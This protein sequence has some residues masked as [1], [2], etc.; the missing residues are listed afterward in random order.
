MADETT[1]PTPDAQATQAAAD[2]QNNLAQ[3]A[4]NSADG[5]NSATTAG[6][7]TASA[8]KLTS[9]TAQLAAAALFG[10]SQATVAFTTG[11][12]PGKI[13]TFNKQLEQIGAI[14]NRK[15]TGIETFKNMAGSM[16]ESLTRMGKSVDS[17]IIQSLGSSSVSVVAG[18]TRAL[19]DYVKTV[20]KAGD[21]L[22]VVREGL[23]AQA[24]ASGNLDQVLHRAGR[25]MQNFNDIASRQQKMWDDVSQASGIAV[26]DVAKYSAELNKVPGVLSTMMKEVHGGNKTNKLFIDTLNLFRISG[27]NYADIT[28][29]MSTATQQMGLSQRAAL[30]YTARMSVAAKEI[31]VPFEELHGAI[32]SSAKAFKMFTTEGAAGEAMAKNLEATMSGYIQTLRSSGI[33]MS[34]AIEMAG[35]FTGAMHE[36]T[37]GQKAF[38]S[39]MTGGPGG[40]MGAFQIEKLMDEGKIDQ[41]FGKVQDTLRKQFGRIVTTSQAAQSQ[42]AA[43]QMTRQIQILRQGP[44]GKFASSDAE[45]RRLLDSMSKPGSAANLQDTIKDMKKDAPMERFLQMGNKIAQ[46]SQGIL[47]NILVATSRGEHVGVSAAAKVTETGLGARTFSRPGDGVGVPDA[48]ERRRE[49]G[50]TGSMPGGATAFDAA[51]R[52]FKNLPTSLKDTLASLGAALKTGNKESIESANAKVQQ[53]ITDFKA[54][55]AALPAD[56]RKQTLESAR[57]VAAL[58]SSAINDV[59]AGVPLVPP[60]GTTAGTTTGT[61][62]VPSPTGTTATTPP[63]TAPRTTPVTTGSGPRV[64]TVTRGGAYTPPSQRVQAAIAPPNQTGTGATETTPG[65]MG[66]GASGTTFG[67]PGKPMPVT[68][69]P[70]STISVNFVGTCPHCKSAINSTE[71]GKTL[72]PAATYHR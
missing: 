21:E 22:K 65:T 19:F 20:V 29:D 17:N 56:Q 1:V 10:V 48:M 49:M 2:A 69:A 8:L 32:T 14:I 30:E 45:A 68:L 46:G 55:A 3:A 7:G 16:V 57:A 63:I 64:P 25:N 18:A 37:L 26:E 4:H 9:Q 71:V 41:V 44:L 43:E 13:T 47:Q 34:N 31:G 28:K 59:K 5:L 42:S 33:P 58:T 70:G 11:I 66:P 15:G 72:N 36:M 23:I 52:D 62:T 27:R 67:Q 54:T 12:D 39:Q 24:V 6:Q 60:P 38:V 40:L 35:N 51:I 53:S 50:R 61:P